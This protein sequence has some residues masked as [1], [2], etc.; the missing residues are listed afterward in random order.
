MAGKKE[1]SFENNLTKLEE[2]VDKL[3][4]NE[5]PLEEA[6]KLF[7]E[8]VVLNKLCTAQLGSAEKAVKKVMEQNDGSY[9]LENLQ[10]VGKE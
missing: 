5:L 2:I 7:Q 10:E 8:G 9:T 4:N 1:A 3:E 6:L